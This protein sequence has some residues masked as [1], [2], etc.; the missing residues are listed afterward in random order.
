MSNKILFL[1]NLI[2][3]EPFRW[4]IEKRSGYNVNLTTNLKEAMQEVK[5]RTYK[6]IIAEPFEF[7]NHK[8]KSQLIPILQ[9]AKKES[10]PILI[11]STQTQTNINRLGIPEELYDY[12]YQK[13][14]NK[15]IYQNYYPQIEKI[16][17]RP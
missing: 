6:L 9:E 10:I 11:S 13:C 3:A 17:N 4:A 7:V 14:F 8:K 1:N 15:N 5:N 2:Y 16:L 12:Y